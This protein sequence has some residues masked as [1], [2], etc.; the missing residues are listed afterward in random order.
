MTNDDID[1]SD[2]LFLKLHSIKG[3]PSFLGA[4]VR[5]GQQAAAEGNAPP[6]STRRRPSV[7]LMLG[8]RHRRCPN[9]KPTLSRRLAGGGWIILGGQ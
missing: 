1:L 8:Q 2:P 9:I 6:A 3:A 4:S 5:P 7:G